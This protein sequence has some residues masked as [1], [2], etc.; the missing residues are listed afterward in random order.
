MN[1]IVVDFSSSEEE[2][3]DNIVDLT[4]E[5]DVDH[6]LHLI[7]NAVPI[8]SS[9]TLVQV[10]IPAKSLYYARFIVNSVG[11]VVNPSF[12]D[13]RAFAAKFV[14]AALAN[15]GPVSPV[16]SRPPP[17]QK[18]Q[19]LA[20]YLTFRFERPLSHFIANRDPYDIY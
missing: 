15:I 4:K 18:P 5:E 14:E 16:F 6:I 8:F 2:S 13:Q 11:R 9:E 20:V 3:D 1:V 10:L 7:G 19:A 12:G 17:P